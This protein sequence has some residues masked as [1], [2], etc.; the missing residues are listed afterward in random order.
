LHSDNSREFVNGVCETLS[1]VYGF[2]IRLG[3]AYTPHMQGK[4]EKFNLF[5]QRQMGKAMTQ[6]KTHCWIKFLEPITRVYNDSRHENGMVPFEAL[7]FI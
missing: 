2:S 3:E 7:H 4:V 6:H 1:A 5:Q